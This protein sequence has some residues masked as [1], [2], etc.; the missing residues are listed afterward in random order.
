MKRSDTFNRAAVLLLAFCLLCMSALSAFAAGG[1]GDGTGG[2]KDQPLVLASSS[3]TNG[4]ENV[5]QTPR[6][7]LTFS[8]NV[9]HFTV[10]DNNKTCFSMTDEN[11]NSVPINVEMGDDQI[12]PS[13]KRIVTIVPQS[14]LKPGTTYLL[15]IGGG[16]TSK[17]GVSIGRDSYI[18]FTTE[19]KKP[20]TTTK[21]TTTKPT[22]T[23]PTTTKPTT[24][25]P[26]TTKPAATRPTTTKPV[27]TKP[28]TTKPVATTAPTA[29]VPSTTAESIT[30]TAATTEVFEVISD[31]AAVEA[32][33]DLDVLETPEEDSSTDEE[34]L[35]IEAFL[36]SDETS[37]T[38]TTAAQTTS[39][40]QVAA[41]D[42]T[43]RA[44][45][46]LRL[47]LLILGISIIAVLAVVL[48]I[49]L[50]HRKKG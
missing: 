43:Q 33:E 14:A 25:R 41:S 27:T 34:A 17:S 23:K 24:T 38:P 6:I 15:K 39:S 32:T 22:T 29:T 46:N 50:T 13:I 8:K 2:G 31:D 49:K 10:R 44:F 11:G 26:T 42:P 30:T 21:P 48:I 7:V 20:V 9:V 12:D 19:G 28:I 3:I 35:A 36:Q 1:N 37:E 40:G 45:Q 18:S 16:I 5:S 47:Y 4:A